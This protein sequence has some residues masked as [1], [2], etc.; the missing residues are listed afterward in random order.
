M[1]FQ[2]MK[3][4]LEFC[5]L[6]NI[7]LIRINLSENLN[8]FFLEFRYVGNLPPSVDESLLMTIFS[9]VGSVIR[10]KMIPDVSKCWKGFCHRLEKSVVAAHERN[11]CTSSKS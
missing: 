9:K 7:L 11:H 3:L 10:C 8:K 1:P 2:T 6:I 5:E 4:T